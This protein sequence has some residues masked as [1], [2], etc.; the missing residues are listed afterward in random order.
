MIAQDTAK[1]D[2]REQVDR[3]VEQGILCQIVQGLLVVPGVVVHIV[4][5]A[6]LFLRNPVDMRLARDFASQPA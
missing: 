2:K 5:V 6:R 4:Q 1:K 3:C